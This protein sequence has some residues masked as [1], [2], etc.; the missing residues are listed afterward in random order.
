L[1]LRT[2]SRTMRKLN[3]LAPSLALD[4]QQESI[5]IQIRRFIVI[6]FADGSALAQRV[7][8][9]LLDL[10]RLLSQLAA[11]SV[12]G[13]PVADGEAA[14]M[15][16]LV[17]NGA[18]TPRARGRPSIESAAHAWGCTR[19]DSEDS[20]RAAQ[21]ARM[22]PGADALRG[23]REECAL[24]VLFA[25]FLEGEGYA[26]TPSK[27]RLDESQCRLSHAQLRAA[28]THDF[29]VCDLQHQQLYYCSAMRRSLPRRSFPLNGVYEGVEV[30]LE[31]AARGAEYKTILQ[32]TLWRNSGPWQISLQWLA[33]AELLCSFSCD[34]EFTEGPPGP[35]LA[36][37]YPTSSEG[38]GQKCAVSSGLVVFWFQETCVHQ[39]VSISHDIALKASDTSA[40]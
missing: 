34:R 14:A 28:V 31:E 35:N 21:G 15:L 9:G 25:W 7:Y 19:K 4:L 3:R 13:A 16:N 32:Q 8:G 37:A 11:T 40:N 33:D 24:G 23:A 18:R 30:F 26:E 12:K 27:G 29:R 38:Q 10:Q 39:V 36:A 6:A 1:G 2:D 17:D 22:S 5:Q 20:R